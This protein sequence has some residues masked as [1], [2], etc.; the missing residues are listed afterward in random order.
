MRDMSL[1]DADRWLASFIPT[2]LFLLDWP[3]ALAVSCVDGDYS[4]ASVSG[5]VVIAPL[6]GPSR[7]V[8]IVWRVSAVFGVLSLHV[9]DI[10]HLPGIQY[11][12]H[13]PVEEGCMLP[14]LVGCPAYR[15]PWGSVVV[16]SE[17][18]SVILDARGNLLVYHALPLRE[19]DC[20]GRVVLV[21][22]VDG[23]WH[24]TLNNLGLEY[25][26]EVR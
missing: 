23:H 5:R 15:A 14:D 26:L 18:R 19:F 6:P 22:R 11:S 4:I 21:Q 12:T 17:S 16:I 2:G 24:L 7:R 10:Y 9:T 8:G 1:R 3:D 20:I 13:L 25:Q